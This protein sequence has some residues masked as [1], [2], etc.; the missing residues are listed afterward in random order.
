M[1]EEIREEIQTQVLDKLRLR[2]SCEHPV[3]GEYD[4]RAPRSYLVGLPPGTVSDGEPEYPAPSVV[5]AMGKRTQAGEG[6]TV[7]II[8]QGVTFGPGLTAPGPKGSEF[9]PTWDGY[10][11]LINLLDAMAQY[12]LAHPVLAGRYEV[13]SPVETILEE[14]Q[15]WPYWVGTLR[16]VVSIPDYHP[17]IYSDFMT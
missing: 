4:L 16:F 15:P 11:D 14:E 8:L 3:D 12:V 17:T 5:V 2:A 6:S 7:E 13:A 9:T 10:W 1:L